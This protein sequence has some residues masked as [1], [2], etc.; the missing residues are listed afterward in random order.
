MH[1]ISLFLFFFT[2]GITTTDIVEQQMEISVQDQ[3]LRK[4]A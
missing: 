1:N 3:K 4:C 2:A